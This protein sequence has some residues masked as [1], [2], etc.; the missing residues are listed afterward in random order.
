MIFGVDIGGVNIKVTCL[1]RM[2]GQVKVQ[3]GSFIFKGRGEMIEK[4]I[5][6]VPHPDIVVI[7]QTMCASR[8]FFSSFR[9]G[10][11]YIVDLTERL[12]GE[13][14]RY[15]GLSYKLYGPEEAKKDYLNVAC[16][17]WVATCYL[18]SYLNLFENG[19]VVDCGTT[20]TD[21]VPVLG[22]TPVTLDDNDRFYTRLKT[23]ELFWSGL[24]FTRTQCQPPLFLMMKNSRSNQLQDP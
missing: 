16:R 20:S 21:I 2:E 7:T 24:Y 15:L 12:F 14:V 18:T 17:N 5:S 13:K 1:D 9:E 3:S 23:G 19:L 22:S 10:T 11:H 8:R 6:L 4:L